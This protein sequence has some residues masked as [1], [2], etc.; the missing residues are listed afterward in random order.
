MG[1]GM[2]GG[3]FPTDSLYIPI[4]LYP[5]IPIY[6][7]CV[8]AWAHYLLIC[9]PNMVWEDV[10][11]LLVSDWLCCLFHHYPDE[12]SR[13]V[14]G[15]GVDK[16]ADFWRQS[17]FDDPRLAAHPLRKN[18]D[19]GTKCIPC[20]MHG[21][22]VP[23]KKSGLSQ[24]LDVQSAFSVLCGTTCTWD[25]MFLLWAL[26]H[27]VLCNQTEHGVDTLE[28]VF[29]LYKWDWWQVLVGMFDPKDC[30][31]EHFDPGSLRGS[32][33][34]THI[35]G[36]FCGALL[37]LQQDMDWAFKAQTYNGKFGFLQDE[38]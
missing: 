2:G 35:A 16:I 19:F 27:D 22:G 12:F 37:Q 34:N 32:R 36:G 21:D 6:S 30:F 14:L 23:Y 10:P 13:R 17:S 4:P 31:G 33:A 7:Q 38:W 25:T 28:I 26:G 29:L 20:G 1:W 9:T 24:T 3:E 5:H 15:G 18:P 8:W 11:V